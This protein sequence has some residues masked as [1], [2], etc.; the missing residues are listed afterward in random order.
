MKIKICGNCSHLNT[1][2]FSE[3]EQCKY[4]LYDAIEKEM[5]VD[6][7]KAYEKASRPAVTHSPIPAWLVFFA[8]ILVI[9]GGIGFFIIVS[10]SSPLLDKVLVWSWAIAYLLS[11]I[12]VALVLFVLSSIYNALYR[13]ECR[14]FK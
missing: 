1:A 10:Y 2:S 12:V 5:S 14:L 13:I 8:W 9:G 11:S 4:P 6:D 7:I 3:C